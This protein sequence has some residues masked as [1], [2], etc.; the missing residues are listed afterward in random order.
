MTRKTF[1]LS[2]S[3]AGIAAA[4]EPKSGAKI[5]ITGAVVDL[6]CYL[7]HDSSGEKHRKCAETCARAG[8]PLA[9]LDAKSKTL[10]LPV[11]MDHSNPN[12][13]LMA[14]IEK[15]VKVTGTLLE[16]SGMKGIAIATIEAAK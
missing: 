11:A 8:N 2:L 1:L 13:P 9:I 3:A 14:H 7:G 16:K 12:T 5:T 10:Y 6:A 15:Q 4:H